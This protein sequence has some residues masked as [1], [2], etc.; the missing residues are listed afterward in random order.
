[1]LS[2]AGSWARQYIQA[3]TGSVAH[4]VEAAGI[5]V[6]LPG[7]VGSLLA[8]FAELARSGHFSDHELSSSVPLIYDTWLSVFA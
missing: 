8:F 5:Q 7:E 1:M 3:V 4:G 6:V 2:L